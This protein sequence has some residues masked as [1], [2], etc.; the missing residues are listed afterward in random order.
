[1]CTL[2][3]SDTT[4]LAKLTAIADLPDPVGPR[5]TKNFL[6]FGNLGMV[7]TEQDVHAA[8]DS[9]RLIAESSH[10]DPF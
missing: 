6:S 3:P 8:A 9:S 2:P 7:Y 4:F 10:G 1:M 5:K